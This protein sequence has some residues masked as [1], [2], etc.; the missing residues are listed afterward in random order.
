MAAQVPP[1]SRVATIRSTTSEDGSASLHTDFPSPLWGDSAV[2]E[3]GAIAS[4]IEG[5][6]FGLETSEVPPPVAERRQLLRPR[7]SLIPADARSRGA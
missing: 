3:S 1:A 2:R 4:L 5:G 7:F 6:G